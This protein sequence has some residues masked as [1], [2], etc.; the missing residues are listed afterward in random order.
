MNLVTMSSALRTEFALSELT[1]HV[2]VL[3]R[4]TDGTG[5]MPNTVK[6]PVL[7]QQPCLQHT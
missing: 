1:K 3:A 7:E 2:P 4:L 6:P 5:L